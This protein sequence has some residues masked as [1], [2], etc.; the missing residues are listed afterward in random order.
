MRSAFD[1][2]TLCASYSWKRGQAR[3]YIRQRRHTRG[4]GGGWGRWRWR[5]RNGD[6]EALG[7]D[8]P[9]ADGT[10]SGVVIH[11][12]RKRRTMSGQRGAFKQRP[13]AS[14]S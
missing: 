5:W 6:L 2:A 14:R 1:C 4:Y 7:D 12:E 8:L 11:G 9:V 13:S 3:K 10:P